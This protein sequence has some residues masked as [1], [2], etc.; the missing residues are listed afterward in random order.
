MSPLAC[1]ACVA[2][3][4]VLAALPGVAAGAAAPGQPWHEKAVVE[5]ALAEAAFKGAAQLHPGVKAAYG[6]YKVVEFGRKVTEKRVDHLNTEID[7]DL[8]VIDADAARLRVLVDE[9]R[10]DDPEARVLVARM[11]ERAESLPG[12]AGKFV[13]RALADRRTLYVATRNYAGGKFFKALGGRISRLLGVRKATPVLRVSLKGIKDPSTRAEW[14]AIR[15]IARRFDVLAERMA[16]VLIAKLLS[17]VYD[18]ATGEQIDE[19]VQDYLARNPPNPVGRDSNDQFR[20]RVIEAAPLYLPVAAV[21]ARQPQLE[22]PV[23]AVPVIV[24]RR[25]ED[26][27]IDYATVQNQ[28]AHQYA[29][30]VHETTPVEQ[31]DWEYYEDRSS[32][33]PDIDLPS[34]NVNWD[35]AG[36]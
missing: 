21:A 32:D 19:A 1:P 35:G 14:K 9:G 3:C 26:P 29:V 10:F 18:T 6:A 7:Q 24:L 22:A 30:E 23:A 8:L 17:D 2:A 11:K 27:V 34:S 25:A 13:V 33:I 5:Q 15:H 36:F 31:T 12:G 16:E 4:L 28:I 20:L